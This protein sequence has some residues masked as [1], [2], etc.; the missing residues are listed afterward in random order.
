MNPC[1]PPPCESMLDALWLLLKKEPGVSPHDLSLRSGI[2]DELL[3]DTIFGVV[4]ITPQTARGI[5]AI[6]DGSER[7]WLN[8]QTDY[9]NYI[10]RL[11][12]HTD[13]THPNGTESDHP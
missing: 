6:F 7:F 12:K 4:P 5:A 3:L 2:E 9:D 8:R 1:T 13:G 10:I 11:H